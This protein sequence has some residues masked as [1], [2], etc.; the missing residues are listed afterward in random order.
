M[1]GDALLLRRGG[2]LSEA[3]VP[4]AGNP[5]A[6]ELRGDGW[7]LELKPGWKVVPVG[8]TADYTI[9]RE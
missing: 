6:G 3:R 1:T 2:R 4:A 7:T 5:Q 8:L 9:T